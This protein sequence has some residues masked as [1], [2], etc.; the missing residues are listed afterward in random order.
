[1]LESAEG[2]SAKRKDAQYAIGST[3]GVGIVDSDD[4]VGLVSQRDLNS[5]EG[6]NPRI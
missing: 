2:S 1:M 5:G 4:L 6:L 3:L